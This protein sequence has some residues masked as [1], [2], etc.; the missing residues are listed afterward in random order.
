MRRDRDRN[1]IVGKREN[2]KPVDHLIRMQPLAV[3]RQHIRR[4]G[5]NGLELVSQG[6]ALAGLRLAQL[7]EDK[8]LAL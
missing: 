7:V 6:A 4:R 8:D 5:D 3:N 2:Q 1:R